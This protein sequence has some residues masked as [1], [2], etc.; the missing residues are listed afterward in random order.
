[1]VRLEESLDV[2]GDILDI[3]KTFGVLANHVLPVDDEDRARFMRTD[4]LRFLIYSSWES[5]V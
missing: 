1:M 2:E 3:D 4:R 5:L